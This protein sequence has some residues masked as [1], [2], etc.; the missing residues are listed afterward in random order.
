MPYGG[1]IYWNARTA[2]LSPFMDGHEWNRL[3]ITKGFGYRMVSEDLPN[4]IGTH[5]NTDVIQS[6]FNDPLASN[7]PVRYEFSFPF[8]ANDEDDNF[9]VQEAVLC[10]APV[11][12]VPGFWVVEVFDPVDDGDVRWLTRPMAWDIHPEVDSVS[13]PAKIYV[14][15]VSD[16]AAAAFSGAENQIVTFDLDAPAK[17]T[18]R[19]MPAF[20]VKP[21]EVAGE[22][23]THNGLYWAIDFEECVSRG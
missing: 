8:L 6:G 13:H 20:K 10:G 3:R 15:G 4:R 23:R 22:F 9:H 14:D 5:A 1:Y 12:F 11:L 21:R 18:I 2:E 17:V 7:V 16:N 19:Y